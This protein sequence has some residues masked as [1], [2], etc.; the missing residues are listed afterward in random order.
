MNNSRRRLKI[1][2]KGKKKETV[3]YRCSLH[4]LCTKASGIKALIQK[5]GTTYAGYFFISMLALFQTFLWIIEEDEL[6][7]N[8]K[9]VKMINKKRCRMWDQSWPIRFSLKKEN[10]THMSCLKKAPFFWQIQFVLKFKLLV[11][12]LSTNC[13]GDKLQ[14]M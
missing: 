1:L 9:A 13:N 2:R 8:T 10:N 7:K 12:W 5:G 6:K 3:P 4:H 14:L 11:K